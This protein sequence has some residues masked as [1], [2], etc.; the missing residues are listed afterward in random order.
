MRNIM[1]DYFFEIN[2]F[3]IYFYL[4]PVFILILIIYFYLN[5]KRINNKTISFFGMFMGLS[6]ANIISLALLLLY[7]YLILV[8]IIVNDFSYLNFLILLV[9]AI[10]FNIINFNILRFLLDLL[11]TSVIFILL[12]S[13]SIFYYYMID[14]G[15]YW[16][17]TLLYGLVCIFIFSYATVIFYRRFKIILNTNKYVKKSQKK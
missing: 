11:N 6:K 9:P 10:C 15:N 8:S 14:V 4:F 13:K 5:K 12:R 1:I 16:Y 2:D 17:I 7:Y 3:L